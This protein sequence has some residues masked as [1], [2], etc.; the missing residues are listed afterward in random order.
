MYKMATRSA[1][2]RSVNSKGK[3][4]AGSAVLALSAGL[5]SGALAQGAPAAS[6]PTGDIETVVVSSSRITASGFSAPTPTTVIGT[7][8][9][10]QNAQ[11]NVFDTINQLPALQGSI[12]TQSNTG[13]F[14]LGQNGLS[15]FNLLGLGTIRTL[16]L[17]DGQRVVPSNILGIAD[18]S[19]FPQLLIKRVDVVTGGASVSWGSDAVGGVVNMVTDTK[20][21]GIKGNIQGSE[22]NYNDNAGL[23]VQVAGGTGFLGGK[24]HIEAS[25][26]FYHTDG[27]WGSFTPGGALTNGRCCAY[28]TGNLAYTPTTTPAGVPEITPILNAQGTNSAIYGLITAG[29]LKGIAFEAN[30]Q[31]TQFQYG[32][33][34]V[35]TTCAGGDQSANIATITVDSPLTRSVFY[36]RLSYDL[37]PEIELYGTFNFGNVLEHEAP[38]QSGTGSL[39]IKCGAAAGGPN[40]YLPAAINT[41]CIANKITTFTFGAAQPTA[42]SNGG[43]YPQIQQHTLRQQRRYVLG[44]DGSFNLLGSDWTFDAYAEHGQANTSIKVYNMWITAR[45]TA[46][47]DAVAGPN[48]TVICR[49]NAITITAPGCVPY[50]VF[51]NGPIS[52]QALN[53]IYNNNNGP[54]SRTHERQ[55]AASFSVNGTP[56]KN[57]AGDV[58]VAFGAEYREE[59]YSTTGDPYSN[60]VSAATPNTA[61][62]PDDPL[63]DPNV[64]GNNWGFANYHVGSGNYH[65]QE[66]FLEFGVPLVNTP[67][68]GKADLDIAGRATNYS[69]SGNVETWKVGL[70]WET[71]LNGVRLRALQSR[72]VRA[73][74]LSELD[75]AEIETANGVI[76]RL[77]PPTSTQ[78]QVLTISVGNPNLRPETAQTTE[79]GVVFQ[80]DYLPGLNASID[81]Y[82]VGIKKQIASLTSQ[83]EID[84]CQLQGNTSYCGLFYLNGA[85]GTANPNFVTLQPFNLSQTTTD[86][87]DIEAT[88][89]FHLQDWGIPGNFV[90]RNLA[91]HVSKFIVNYGVA[92]QP[93][94]EFA[95][96]QVTYNPSGGQFLASPALWKL[97]MTQS[98]TSDPFEFDV[99]ERYFSPGVQNPYGIQ[100]Q[101][102]NCPVPT[103]QNPTYSNNKVPGYLYVD[104][105]GHYQISDMVQAYFKVNNVADQLPKPFAVLNSDPVGRMYRVGIRFNN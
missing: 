101:A 13:N 51:G 18:V 60:G 9:I 62:Y 63:F 77:I 8:E 21:D 27:V 103:A 40:F 28:N 92:G 31:P 96:A 85:I 87:F 15:S 7:A 58:A 82:R 35:G 12:G 86:G 46:A 65:V 10:E 56:F 39:T 38:P 99:T 89:Q 73:P 20:F 91:N 33:P 64:Q 80:P 37:T 14:S 23:L 11:P 75:A 6:A 57:W 2:V 19:L 90:L 78:P 1:G 36:T 98:W 105:G 95:G 97:Y 54:Y 61:A 104:V 44:T 72:D 17:I 53:Y 83:Q 59:G 52:S 50:S 5:A 74:N 30:G 88:Y 22:S 47:T 42:I 41:A 79:L 100:C 70:T 4:F 93:V 66:A 94:A 25:A 49:A 43:R 3:W 32:S 102:P 26:E 45:R 81:Y 16:T 68:W 24:A 29:P 55:E 76:N 84:L 67:D 48:G 69:T 34:C 71:P